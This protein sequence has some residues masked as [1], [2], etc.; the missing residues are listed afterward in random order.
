MKISQ[1]LLVRKRRRRRKL[2]GSGALRSL[3][4]APLL[5]FD[6]TFFF[7]LFFFASVQPKETPVVFRPP[8]AFQSETPGAD[9]WRRHLRQNHPRSSLTLL[10]CCSALGRHP[11]PRP[12]VAA[13]LN[14]SGSE[15]SHRGPY[16]Q[17][18]SSLL[19]CRA[20]RAEG[21]SPG[22]RH[23]KTRFR[24]CS[25]MRF[26]CMRFTTHTRRQRASS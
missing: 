19:E 13:R 25:C 7:F 9:T 15:D 22:T 4:C 21:S 14:A 20:A 17:T 8:A 6:S 24:C 12:A 18:Q 10:C 2:P 1:G 11:A 16:Q 23:P 26:T 5:I 3:R